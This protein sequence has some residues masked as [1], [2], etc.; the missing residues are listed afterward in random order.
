MDETSIGNKTPL[1][2]EP[3]KIV[4]NGANALQ[5]VCDG[6]STVSACLLEVFCANGESPFSVLTTKTELSAIKKV[7]LASIIE[8]TVLEYVAL[9]SGKF[10]AGHHT[11]VLR[12]IGELRPELPNIVI[13]D[14]PAFHTTLD[15]IRAARESRITLVGLPHNSS[16][17]LQQADDLPFTL[18]KDAHYKRVKQFTIDNGRPP[19]LFETLVIYLEERARV[20]TPEII[21]QSFKRGGQYHP[22]LK[23]PSSR[24]IQHKA[25]MARVRCSDHPLGKRPPGLISRSLQN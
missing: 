11:T 19:K 1:K 9:E 6:Q 10:N 3:V 22:E 7:A 15:S 25:E 14:C 13:Q 12:K 2:Y 5:S 17:F 21:V 18:N 8:P 20:V 16:W 4:P 24:Q 23:S